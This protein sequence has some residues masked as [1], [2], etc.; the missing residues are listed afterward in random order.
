MPY[1]PDKREYRSIASSFQAV[2]HSED[3]DSYIIEGYA[4]TFDVPYDFGRGGMKECISSR[5]LDAAD[6][7]DVVLQLNHEGAPLARLKNGSLSIDMDSHGLHVR[8][9]LS[10]SKMGR[11]LYEAVSNGLIDSM[12]WGFTVADD[13]WSYDR[14]NRTATVERIDKVYDVSIVT[15]PANADTEVHARSYLDGVIEEEKQELLQRDM[16]KRMRSALRLRLI[17][18]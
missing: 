9:D 7:T 16:E 3:S 2:E 10:G 14:Q 15:F 11:E 4:T 1:K 5:A 12:S 13:G 8:A 6:M 18:L 17:E